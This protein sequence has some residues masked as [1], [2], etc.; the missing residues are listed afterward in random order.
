[1]PLTLEKCI[2]FKSMGTRKG[3]INICYMA[4]WVK[5]YFLKNENSQKLAQ[6]FTVGWGLLFREQ[7]HPDSV[8]LFCVPFALLI[9]LGSI[10][11]F[12]PQTG[13]LSV[14]VTLS[15]H[16]Q[17]KP[18]IAKSQHEF[19]MSELNLASARVV[20]VPMAVVHLCPQCLTQVLAH[21]RRAVCIK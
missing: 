12:F 16:Y 3:K 2:R 14:A 15:L 1:M 6:L 19:P 10:L 13:K 9:L 8:L 11:T 5:T 20:V 17:G 7:P 18:L 4:G 21:T